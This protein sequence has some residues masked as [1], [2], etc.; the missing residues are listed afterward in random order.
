MKKNELNNNIFLKQQTFSV[1]NDYFEQ[2][3]KNITQKSENKRFILK[4]DSIKN[5]FILSENY[6]DNLL[7]HINS[8]IYNWK[9][10]KDIKINDIYTIPEQYFELLPLQ[11]QD[12]LLQKQ[13]I[14]IIFQQNTLP[15]IYYTGIAA[16]LVLGLYFGLT[17]PTKNKCTD[18]LCKI[19]KSEIR[20]YLYQQNDL[21]QEII[22]ENIKIQNILT[23]PSA[24]QNDLI[25]QIDLF[26]IEYEL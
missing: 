18:L 2:S 13:K 21:N 12:K 10:I 24:Y 3:F 23:K 19:T 11:I 8:K 26:Q 9:K 22:I 1:P 20:E 4:K 14:I 16:M 5:N 25:E 17:I 15:K 6:F 7:L